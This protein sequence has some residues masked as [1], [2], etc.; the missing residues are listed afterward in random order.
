MKCKLFFFNILFLSF[1]IGCQSP[2]REFDEYNQETKVTRSLRNINEVK[3][4]TYNLHLFLGVAPLEDKIRQ[5][6]IS[7]YIRNNI[8]DNDVLYLSEIWKDVTKNEIIEKLKDIYPFSIHSNAVGTSVGDGLLI[9]SKF[10]IQENAFIKYKSAAGW[11]WFSPKGFHKTRFSTPK[12]VFY[13]FFT[14]TQADSDKSAIRRNQFKQIK[15]EMKDL[16]QVPSI[17]TGDL[18]VI[19]D[20]SQEYNE[21][22]TFF[23]TYRDSYREANQNL[24][25][26]PGYT[27][28]NSMN[29]LANYFYPLSS[30][31]KSQERLDYI[32]VSEGWN[33]VA[34]DLINNCNY[35]SGYL[36][37][38]ASCS[39]HYGVKATLTL[40]K[41]VKKNDPYILNS[42]DEAVQ[43]INSLKSSYGTGQSA[44]IIIHNKTDED[45]IFI[46]RTQWYNSTFFN[47]PSSVIPSGKFGVSLATHDTGEATGVFNQL[48]YSLGGDNI[49]FGTYVPWSWAYTNNVLVGFNEIS[50]SELEANSRRPSITKIQNN[51]KLTGKTSTGD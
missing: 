49:S 22:K 43:K 7:D 28:D 5:N 21:L 4:A 6:K 10:P 3:V 31:G 48:T 38:V 44:K 36:K 20:T 39:D 51:I 9:L 12:G 32:L 37:S 40:E 1:C 8:S 47:V 33:I 2:G 41:S 15:E 11:D 26:Y 30:N 13:S 17:I 42:Y 19:G 23:Q 35:E 34:S 46:N 16:D 25:D 14:H 27:Y 50:K 29:K 24:R 45:L 18:N